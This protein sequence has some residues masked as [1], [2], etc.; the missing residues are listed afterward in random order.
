MAQHDYSLS[1]G[2][3]ILRDGQPFASI[4]R[5]GGEPASPLFAFEDDEPGDWSYCKSCIRIL[6]LNRRR[7]NPLPYPARFRVADVIET[8]P[9]C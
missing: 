9:G 1:P 3:C 2:R 8:T 5:A 7:V 6:S 4:H